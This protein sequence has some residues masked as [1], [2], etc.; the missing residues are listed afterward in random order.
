M[1]FLS[2]VVQI[3]S[4]PG[5]KFHAEILLPDFSMNLQSSAKRAAYARDFRVEANR[6]T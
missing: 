4:N 3:L 5:K 1:K 6:L 2:T